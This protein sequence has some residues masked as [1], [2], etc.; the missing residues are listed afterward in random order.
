VQDDLLSLEFGRLGMQ[1]SRS[2]PVSPSLRFLIRAAL[3]LV[4]LLGVIRYFA[5]PYRKLPPGPPGYQ[6]IGNLL[7][8]MWEEQSQNGEGNTVSSLFLSSL[9]PFFLTEPDLLA[10]R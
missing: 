6:I 4:V 2:H 7:D 10:T 3:D 5:S 9:D 8:N 1:Q